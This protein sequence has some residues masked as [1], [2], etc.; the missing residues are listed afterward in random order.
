[1][2]QSS[3]NLPLIVPTTVSPPGALIGF[4]FRAEGGEK[5]QT[6]DQGGACRHTDM[7]QRGGWDTS[8]AAR[9]ETSELSQSVCDALLLT[10]GR[11]LEPSPTSRTARRS[12][13]SCRQASE[14]SGRPTL[15]A[16][17]KELQELWNAINR[18][19]KQF[20]GNSWAAPFLCRCVLL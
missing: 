16:P 8:R 13:D 14:L 1:M 11:R 4:S 5:S 17:G 9:S 18:L 20:G 15:R 7:H 10:P 2:A 12:A 3:C 6:C 19:L